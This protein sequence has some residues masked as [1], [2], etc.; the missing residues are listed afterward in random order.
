MKPNWF[1]IIL[2]ALLLGTITFMFF[3]IKQLEA[4]RQEQVVKDV[5]TRDSLQTKAYEYADS[6]AA[7]NQ[8]IHTKTTERIIHTIE[9]IR[10]EMDSTHFDPDH[11]PNF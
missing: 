8:S 4:D 3:H 6:V 9:T 2:S 1:A 7:A 11:L 5:N 10:Y